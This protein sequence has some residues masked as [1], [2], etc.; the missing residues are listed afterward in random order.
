MDRSQTIIQY[1]PYFIYLVLAVFCINNPFF[2]DT[3][4]LSSQQATWFYDTNFSQ[5]ILPQEIDSGHPP[6]N[7]IMLASL[8]KIFGRSLWVGHVFTLFWS[9]IMIFQLQKLAKHLFSAKLALLVAIVVLVD[10]TLLAQSSLVSPDI[11]L[12]AALFMAL[13]G[14]FEQKRWL[15]VIAIFFLSLISVR[16]MMCT[17]ALY[18]IYLYYNYKRHGKLSFRKLIGLSIPFLPGVVLALSFLAYHYYRT[19]WIGHH[20]DMP[21]ASCFEKV[22]FMGFLKNI[23]VMVWRFIDFGRITIFILLFYALYRL[24]NKTKSKTGQVNYSLEQKIIM[25]S[26]VLMLLLFS[27]S[28]LLHVLLSCHRYILP[29]YALI[30]LIT[31]IFLEKVCTF[32]QIRL[33]VI[34]SIVSLLAG[35]LIRYPEKIATGWDA[36]L[37]HLPYYSLRTEMLDYIE[38]QN[39]PIDDVSSGFVVAGNQNMID[40]RSPGNKII[41]QDMET[42]TYFIYSN[43]SNLDDEIIDTVL[44]PDRYT[45]IKRIERGNVFFALYKKTSG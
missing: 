1:I 30:I 25:I 15:L 32:K 41:S 7:G 14:I 29:L 16:G 21:W 11:I 6:L 45:L 18:F 4:Q 5:L 44:N 37:S 23:G 13:N 12:M 40:L 19:G 34:I 28:F 17:A 9:F 3:V 27:Y 2:F 36:T 35:N 8:W 38:S 22:D 31:F 20:P 43:I 10:P 24:Y 33:F 42:T 26:F 39:I